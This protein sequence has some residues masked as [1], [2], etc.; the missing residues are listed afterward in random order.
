MIYYKCRQCRVLLE[1][2]DRL[3]GRQEP[4]PNCQA[5]NKVPAKSKRRHLVGIGLTLVAGLV[6]VATTVLLPGPTG[7]PRT[8]LGSADPPAEVEEDRPHPRAERAATRQI[9]AE[10]SNAA[11]K[12]G[13]PLLSKQPDATQLSHTQVKASVEAETILAE[14]ERPAEDRLRAFGYIVQD[15]T[16]LV[17]ASKS[18]KPDVAGKKVVVV[19]V[20]MPAKTVIPSAAEHARWIAGQHGLDLKRQAAPREQCL[21]L[22]RRDFALR[23]GGGRVFSASGMAVWTKQGQLTAELISRVW[24]S[25]AGSKSMPGSVA[26]PLSWVLEKEDFLPPFEVEHLRQ[27][28]AVPPKLLSVREVKAAMGEDFGLFEQI[29][30]DIPKLDL[31]KFQPPVINLPKFEAPKCRPDPVPKLP[32]TPRISWPRTGRRRPMSPD[33]DEPRRLYQLGQEYLSQGIKTKA[34][35]CFSELVRRYPNS[36]FAAAARRKLAGLDVNAPRS[37]R[38]RA[39][40]RRQVTSQ[41]GERR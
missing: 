26:A 30:I 36:G 6:L 27:L 40:S 17:G 4:C 22:D 24:R 2:E 25:H 13:S 29:K 38:G 21:R 8:A 28:I 5:I 12:V 41:Q 9:A 35:G 16:S 7:H 33:A 32:Q 3:A 31:P 15:Y 1:T 10:L 20:S 18:R 19:I 14:A 34:E 39:S 11:G 37:A 23:N